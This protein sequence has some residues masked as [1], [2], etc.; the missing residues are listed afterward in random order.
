MDYKTLKSKIE[1]KK[2]HERTL[3]LLDDQI[4]LYIDSKLGLRGMTYEEVKVQKSNFGD[5]FASTFADIEKLDKER[6]FE[7]KQLELI[8]DYLNDIDK[9]FGT[10]N[11][12][13]KAIFKLKYI[14]GYTDKET[15]IELDVCEKTISR[16]VKKILEK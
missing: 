3:R 9:L 11:N 14:Y 13:E 16:A 15:S 10:L 12:R 6:E 7:K 5:K 1:D 4:K 2:V 8:N